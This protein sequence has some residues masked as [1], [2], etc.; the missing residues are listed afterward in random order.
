[1]RSKSAVRLSG[2]VS[3]IWDDVEIL[4]RRFDSALKTRMTGLTVS[5]IGNYRFLVNKNLQASASF[6]KNL[7]RRN[8]PVSPKVS[9]AC[10]NRRRR[11]KRSTSTRVRSRRR[12]ARLV[13]VVHRRRRQP[14][15]HRHFS[16][17][18]RCGRRTAEPSCSRLP[19]TVKFHRGKYYH[20]LFSI[21]LLFSF[22]FVFSLWNKVS[23][24]L[25]SF[26]FTN[27]LLQLLL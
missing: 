26:S 16:P 22:Q 19:T 3:E 8:F 5:E 13:T 18:R 17:M 27:I 9:G 1:L 24:L 11:S 14:R 15:I 23:P 21:Y 12:F 20:F 6:T 7:L 25:F 4:L 10:W 2:I